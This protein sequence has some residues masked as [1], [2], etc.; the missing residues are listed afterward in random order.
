[1]SLQALVAL[2]LSLVLAVTGSDCE[3]A[4]LVQARTRARSPRDLAVVEPP[5]PMPWGH[6]ELQ[7][8]SAIPVFGNGTN[9]IALL[10]DYNESLWHYANENQL[11]CA[12]ADGSHKAAFKLWRAETVMISQMI[13]AF[14]CPWPQEAADGAYHLIV[15]SN[16]G[17]LGEV[18]T[19]QAPNLL[20]RHETIACIN[21]A[22]NTPG[23][24]PT[25]TRAPQ[26]LEYNLMH[27]VGHF[28]LYTQDGMDQEFLQVYR[29]YLQEGLATRIHITP[30]KTQFN[31][32]RGM[33]YSTQNWV[34]N[35]CLYRA[36]HHAR[37]VM[38]TIDLDEYL[39][40]KE[41]AP[42]AWH[43]PHFMAKLWDQVA[44]NASKTRDEVHAVMLSRYN[45]LISPAPELEVT[46]TLRQR[47][48]APLCPKYV[49]NPDAVNLAFVHWPT[50]WAEGTVSLV[51]P[52][53]LASLN[54]YR[55]SEEK[56]LGEEMRDET[57]VPEA[58]AIANALRA[59][60]RKPW[61]ELVL[62]LTPTAAA[63]VPDVDVP[64]KVDY[65]ARAWT[66]FNAV[67]DAS[68]VEIVHLRG[69]LTDP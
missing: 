5:A 9:Y 24:K 49:L 55:F 26:W 17:V 53:D 18:R 15:Q 46:S 6:L 19:R 56:Y 30:V 32:S 43:G 10:H 8:L 29:P 38:P 69:G 36:K 13:M 66:C 37:W 48:V 64:Q 60:F 44:A 25:S 2:T 39:V 50:N 68:K 52:K 42:P 16:E 11:F 41:S 33:H 45:F 12:S 62:E 47:E 3:D 27:G 51:L 67:R 7:F 4:W 58:P 28:L 31:T 63:H 21:V 34:A 35:D 54:H 23:M 61:E 20:G 14:H 57:L 1:M 59:R 65:S 22:W 40:L